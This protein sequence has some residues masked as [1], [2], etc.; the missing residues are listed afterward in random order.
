MTVA[1]IASCFGLMAVASEEDTATKHTQCLFGKSDA[2][3]KEVELK[4]ATYWP[5]NIMILFG[6]PGKLQYLQFVGMDMS[7]AQIRVECGIVSCSSLVA[8]A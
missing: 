6:P 3:A 7:A 5:R 4:F 2:K 8:T 1:G